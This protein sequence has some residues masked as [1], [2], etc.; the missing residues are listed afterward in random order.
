MG[1]FKKI[2]HKLKKAK[3]IGAKI[4]HGV[5]IG[6]RKVGK[7]V[8][9]VAELSAPLI[10]AVGVATGQ[11]EILALGKMAEQASHAG[12]L[13][14][15]VGREGSSTLNARGSLADKIT[16]SVEKKE[17]FDERAKKIKDEMF[18]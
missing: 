10:E 5:A 14:S 1:F 15:D 9:K 11:P 16:S 4:A 13:I 3:H 2:G 8:K 7:T 6:A 18:K 17:K 12:D